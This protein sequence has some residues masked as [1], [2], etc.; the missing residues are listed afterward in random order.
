MSQDLSSTENPI[1]TKAA[2]GQAIPVTNLPVQRG[3][4]H[5]K[6]QK[7]RFQRLRTGL[8]SLLILFFFLL[9]FIPYQEIGRAHV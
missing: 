1:A 2:L 9:P 3:K 8:N 6:E 5:I 7:G 4:I